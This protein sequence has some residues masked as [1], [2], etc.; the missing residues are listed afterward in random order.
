MTV[1]SAGMFTLLVGNIIHLASVQKYSDN[2]HFFITGYKAMLVFKIDFEMTD[3]AY[4]G[5]Y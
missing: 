5:L 3:F 4:E 2:K 1:I